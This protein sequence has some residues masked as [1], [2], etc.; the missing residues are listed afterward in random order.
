[1]CRPC[2]LEPLFFDPPAGP[3]TPLLLVVVFPF[4]LFLFNKGWF[5]GNRFSLHNDILNLRH[6]PFFPQLFVEGLLFSRPWVCR[7][8]L[9]EPLFFDPPAGPGTPLCS[10]YVFPFY[11]F[12]FN[13]GW[14]SGNRFSLHNDIL[15]LRHLQFFPQLFVEGLLF[16]RPWVCRPCLL[17]PL[18]F[19]P[20]AGPGT[21]LLLLLFFPFT[22]SFLIKAGFLE[23]D[24]HYTT[25]F[26]I[27]ATYRFSH[28]FLLRV[29][30]S[31]APECVDRVCWNRSFSTPPRAQEH[32][33]CYCLFFPFTYSFLI[34]AGF[35]ETDFH[36][37]TIFWIFATY[38]F[39]HNFL[40]R[41]SF[42]PAPECVD[43]VCWNR[44]FSTPP[45]AQEHR[46]LLLL[47]F[48]FTYSFLIK[49]GFLETDFHYTTIFW[50]FATY[51]FSHNFLL[52][53]SFS[54]A[55]EC[56]DRVCWNRS[57]STPP[58]AQEHRC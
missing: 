25:I 43:R 56:V 8:C 34:K 16:S 18:F 4:Y 24:F 58:R 19:D 40:L 42:S 46:L 9:L 39:S 22:Y 52:R 37:T 1:M 41:V 5:S 12:L 31:P 6:L 57:F 17:E 10:C 49:A 21:P 29:S 45:R 53:V 27:F 44:S 15:N 13:K 50:I 48:P 51:R 36:Y 2:L 47:F 28:N 35:L 14:F 3:G 20:P 55:P 23:T 30:F 7:P 26:W 33:C 38:R 32:R 11:L 54:P